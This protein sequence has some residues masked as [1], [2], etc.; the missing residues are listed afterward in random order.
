MTPS[1]TASAPRLSFTEKLAYGFGDTASNFFF[2]AFNLFLV[3]YYT[4]IFG[5]APAAVGT[6]M[7]VTRGLDAVMDPVVGILADRT[8]SRWGKFRPYIL[9]GAVPYGV[10]GY[11]MFAGPNL[12]AHGKLVYAY[13]TYIL[14]WVAYT[15]INIPYSALMGV[16]SPS[17]EDRTSLS[18]FRFSCAFTGAFLVS[19]FTL[20]LKNFLGGSNPENG[21]RY[22]MAIFAVISVAMFLFTF[23][24]TRER[25]EPPKNQEVSLKKD[26]KGLSQNKP[27]LVL[28]FAAFLTLANVGMRNAAIVY[29]FKYNVGDNGHKVFLIFDS[30]SLFMSIGALVFIAGAFSTKLFTR[31]F[32]RRKLMIVLTSI[33]AVGMAAFYFVDP[34]NL[35]AL[36]L[37]NIV[38]TFAA[39]PTPAI[40]WSMY[41]DT[42]DYGEWKFGRRSTGLVFSAAVFAQKIGLAVG[43]ALLGWSLTYYG[44][45]PNA[46]QTA[47]AQHGINLMFS[48]LP[49]LLGLLSGLVIIWYTLDESQ[50][51]QVE[52]ELA[53]R[54]LAASDAAA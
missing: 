34:K 15:A 24:K 21:F 45:V 53:E 23:A 51:K 16:M 48:L 4:D 29:Y 49:G 12:S 5:L 38:A 31:Y 52:R 2:Q 13:V 43:S 40:V 18:A 1:E 26:L 7:L 42:A 50:V 22:T 6:L 32:S 8:R 46:V 17:S 20:P 9:F 33:N 19:S 3:F 14:M 44:F 39:G 11:L 37:L 30:T 36:N 41:A 35:L 47:R 27:W 54:K 10:M 28:F 25:V